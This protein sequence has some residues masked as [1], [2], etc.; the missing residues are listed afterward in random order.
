MSGKNITLR[1]QSRRR[2][3]RKIKRRSGV[4]LCG[5]LLP[6]LDLSL[7]NKLRPNQFWSS[8]HNARVCIE[9]SIY[10]YIYMIMR[11]RATATR[12]LHRG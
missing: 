2:G 5:G 7:F 6:K 8:A 3:G 12:M 4:S 10:I 11:I 9:R 1:M